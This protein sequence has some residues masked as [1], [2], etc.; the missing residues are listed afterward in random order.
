MIRKL[1]GVT[2]LD[3]EFDGLVQIESFDFDKGHTTLYYVKE[4]HG[5]EVIIDKKTFEKPLRQ[6]FYRVL[7]KADEQGQVHKRFLVP[8]LFYF[9]KA[10][11][12]IPRKTK[13]TALHP[14]LV[15]DWRR[16]GVQQFRLQ[17]NERE[18]SIMGWTN[19]FQIGGATYDPVYQIPCLLTIYQKQEEERAKKEARER[20]AMEAEERAERLRI[21]QERKDEAR[22]RQAMIK[23]E[24]RQRAHDARVAFVDR[25]K[26]SENLAGFER[27]AIEDMV[28]RAP[29]VV[30]K[31]PPRR[32]DAAQNVWVKRQAAHEPEPGDKVV[33]NF[34]DHTNDLCTIKSANGD[35]LKSYDVGKFICWYEMTDDQVGAVVIWEN[36]N[37]DGEHVIDSHLAIVPACS[38]RK[39]EFHDYDYLRLFKR[40]PNCPIPERTGAH[41]SVMLRVIKANG[42]VEKI[43]YWVDDRQVI[44]QAN[45]SHVKLHMHFYARD[46][47]PLAFDLVNHIAAPDQSKE[48]DGP[49]RDQVCAKYF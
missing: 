16:H 8:F 9:R 35:F 22:E 42:Q 41:V 33:R 20:K 18:S 28:C 29:L 3:P 27:V 17:Q 43:V 25:L 47:F 32:G 23:E 1:P 37:L 21:K 49:D 46:R 5:D 40:I 45:V 31:P 44:H 10:D 14:L 30:F 11:V 36:R 13:S 38:I 12:L 48:L 24:D 34:K 7:Q 6:Y 4:F 19:V 15:H 39:A 2:D 26:E